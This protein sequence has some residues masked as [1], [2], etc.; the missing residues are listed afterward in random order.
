[1]PE[2]PTNGV[3]PFLTI[4]EKRGRE[5]VEFYK[6]AF[7]AEVA[8]EN[9]AQDGQRL[10]QAGLKINGG[11]I[12][13]SDEFPEY[14]GKEEPPAQGTILHLQVDN[15]DKWA[16]RAESAGAEIIMPLADQFWGDR[17]GQLR[18]PFGH[19]WSVGSPL[20]TD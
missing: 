16:E 14:T 9:I 17:Y 7:N 5:A 10:M 19:K 2:R 18:D 4:R 8:E 1:M 6:R 13:L 3:T 20:K 15:A 11:W 12:M